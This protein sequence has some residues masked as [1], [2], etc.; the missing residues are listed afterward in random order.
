LGA[1]GWFRFGIASPPLR[2]HEGGPAKARFHER[3]GTR[4]RY[5]AN[6]HFHAR[7]GSGMRNEMRACALMLAKA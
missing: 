4:F 6:V 5:T 2:R 3:L 1:G 7:G